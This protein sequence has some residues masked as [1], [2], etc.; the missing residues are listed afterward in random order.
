M[1]KATISL[2]NVVIII[3]IIALGLILKTG[4]FSLSLGKEI[5][6]SCHHLRN[7]LIIFLLFWAIRL[8][9]IRNSSQTSPPTNNIKKNVILK[10][11]I[12]LWL[13][14][15]LFSYQPETFSLYLPP[16]NHSPHPIITFIF[17][18][19][20]TG[21]IAYYIYLLTKRTFGF[22][23]AIIAVA[24]F[25]FSPLSRITTAA[26]LPTHT[27]FLF[28]LGSIVYFVRYLDPYEDERRYPPSSANS[29]PAKARA[30]LIIGFSFLLGAFLFKSLWVRFNV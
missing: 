14:L 20:L 13:G 11:I 3:N 16:F 18:C 19:L 6:L 8:I 4:G 7:P 9:L 28:F 10:L 1:K 15:K 30:N 29:S 23:T 21:S 27:I 2:I 5:S 17:S 25:L 26:L 24:T 12:L 22:L